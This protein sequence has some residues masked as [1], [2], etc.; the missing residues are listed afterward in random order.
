[1]KFGSMGNAKKIGRNVKT[2]RVAAIF[3]ISNFLEGGRNK[4]LEEICPYLTPRQTV[5][6]RVK[7]GGRQIKSDGA[8]SWADLGER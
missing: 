3:E 5:P 1:M 7:G 6:V 8:D 2:S 4:G